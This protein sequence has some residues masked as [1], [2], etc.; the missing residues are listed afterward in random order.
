MQHKSP[1]KQKQLEFQKSRP[2][3]IGVEV[4]FQLLDPDTLDLA[5]RAPAVLE[6][7]SNEYGDRIKKEFIQSMVEV[8]TGICATPADVT[9]DMGAT[10]AALEEAAERCKC[11][12]HAA[13]LHPFARV[14]DQRL[15]D[16]ERYRAILD[17]L[18]IVGRRLITQGL[19]VHIG[20]ADGE[21]AI[22]VFDRMRSLLPLFLALTASSPFFESEDTGLCSYRSKLFEALPRSGM[23]D[24]LGSW[25]NYRDFVA[26]LEHAQVIGSPRDIWWDVRPHPELGTVE[27][28]I[29]DV[30][31]RFR[32]VVAV[33]SLIQA[34]ALYLATEGS[35]INPENRAIINSNKW[36]AVR[37]GLQARFVDPL[38]GNQSYAP[39][40]IARL[41]R[42]LE[43]FFKDFG[44]SDQITVLEGMLERGCSANRQRHIFHQTGSLRE[45]IRKER[46]EFHE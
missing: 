34:S 9:T 25:A 16:E 27:V 33:A 35:S 20:M 41:L 30:P 32:C 11:L 19:H 22:T 42:R 45:I 3:T 29:C 15:S 36:Q 24:A 18:Q 10:I 44:A 5:H 7:T 1:I 23:P 37:H 17:E 31:S 26:L 2:F 28:R 14:R 4:E 13:S 39:D 40:A 12:I 38:T 43:P 8:T 21:T 6:Q 46:M